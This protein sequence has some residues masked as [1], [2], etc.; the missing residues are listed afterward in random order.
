MAS[1]RWAPEASASWRRQAFQPSTDGASINR[2]CR[3]SSADHATILEAYRGRSAGGLLIN[4]EVSDVDAEFDRLVTDGSLKS[5]L[6]IR[7]EDFGQRHFIVAAPD[8]VLID[9]ISAIEPWGSSPFS[10]LDQTVCSRAGPY[11]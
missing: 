2:I 3:D 7:S 6:S 8:G 4:I 5:V 10:R 1:L 9:V 11:F